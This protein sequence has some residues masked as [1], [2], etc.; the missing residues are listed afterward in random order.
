MPLTLPFG[1]RGCSQAAPSLKYGSRASRSS[2]GRSSNGAPIHSPPHHPAIPPSSC[3]LA[4]IRSS[5][6]HTPYP[7]RDLLSTLGRTVL[8]TLWSA[9]HHPRLYPPQ[10][11]HAG[12]AGPPHRWVR[13]H[14]YGYFAMHARLSR[15][16]HTPTPDPCAFPDAA[17]ISCRLMLGGRQVHH[18]S[19]PRA[20]GGAVW[21]RRGVVG[22]GALCARGTCGSRGQPICA[23]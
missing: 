23:F 5:P 14:F 13:G 7:T 19:R 2:S 20:A 15:C 3:T 1:S 16:R 11:G 9:A 22:R 10:V 21:A 8:A 18:L 6:P 4:H 17:L 12:H